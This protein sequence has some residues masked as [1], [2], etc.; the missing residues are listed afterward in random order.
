MER[1]F[2]LTKFLG[3]S[4]RKKPG[5]LKPLPYTLFCRFTDGDRFI[6]IHAEQERRFEALKDKEI[7]AVKF[8]VSEMKEFYN[9]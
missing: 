3:V 9:A 1:I 2:W 8:P 4:D 6:K 7:W 5:K